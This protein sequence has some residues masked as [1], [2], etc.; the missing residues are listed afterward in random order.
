MANNI[1]SAL[2][3]I[4]FA[5]ALLFIPTAIVVISMSIVEINEHISVQEELET[6]SLSNNPYKDLSLEELEELQERFNKIQKEII[7]EQQER[8]RIDAGM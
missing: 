2:Q 6:E 5:I 1:K 8:A 7:E 4:L 3:D